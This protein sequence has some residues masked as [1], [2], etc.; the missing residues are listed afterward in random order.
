MARGEL[1]DIS[2]VA[3]AVTSDR[4]TRLLKLTF[5][6]N[7]RQR[8]DGRARAKGQVHREGFAVPANRR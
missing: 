1:A 3:F 6:H 7:L 4:N 2:D 8:S 5:G